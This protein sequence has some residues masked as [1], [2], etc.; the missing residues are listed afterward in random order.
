MLIRKLQELKVKERDAEKHTVIA[1]HVTST[2]RSDKRFRKI[3]KFEKGLFHISF[4]I[5]L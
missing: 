1:D 3:A 2:L 4:L 5:V